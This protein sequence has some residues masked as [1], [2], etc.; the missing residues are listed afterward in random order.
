MWVPKK[1]QVGGRVVG[2]GGRERNKER[3]KERKDRKRKKQVYVVLR[4]EETAG[5]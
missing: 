4:T 1:K 2:K 3:R 5:R